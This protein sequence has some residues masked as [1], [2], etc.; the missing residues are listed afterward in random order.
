[1][2]TLSSKK[3]TI[4][5]WRVESLRVDGAANVVGYRD[6]GKVIKRSLIK[7]CKDF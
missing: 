3:V 5:V 7:M 4:F 6:F 1:M 2:V